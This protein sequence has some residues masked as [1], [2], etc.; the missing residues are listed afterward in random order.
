M[1]KIT[2]LAMGKGKSYFVVGYRNFLKCG[3]DGMM[4]IYSIL[5]K[6]WDFFFF[7]KRKEGGVT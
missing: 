2:A 1:H 4:D 3:Y 5:G 7:S 6:P